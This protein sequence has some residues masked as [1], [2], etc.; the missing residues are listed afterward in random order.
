M[1]VKK[2]DMD[3]GVLTGMLGISVNGGQI[4]RLDVM[5]HYAIFIIKLARLMRNTDF[6]MLTFSFVSNRWYT[7]TGIST[8]NTDA[9]ERHDVKHN[10]SSY[11]EMCPKF[12]TSPFPRDSPLTLIFVLLIFIRIQRTRRSL[13]SSLHHTRSVSEPCPEEHIGIREQPLF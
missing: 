3:C 5:Y 9:R 8:T 13:R 4:L 11:K 1:R 7:D 6:P 12:Y 10:K 2:I